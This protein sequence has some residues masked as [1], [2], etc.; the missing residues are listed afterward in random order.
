[1]AAI[2][3]SSEVAV[4]PRHL[5]G[6]VATWCVVFFVLAPGIRAQ[7]NTVLRHTGVPHDWS[8]SHIVFSRDALARHPELIHLEPRIQQQ[9]AQRQQAV[10]WGAYHGDNLLSVLPRKSRLNRD[11]N[12]NPLGGRLHIDMFPAKYSFDPNAA[13][14]CTNDYVVFGLGVPGVNGGTANFVAFNNLYSDPVNGGGLCDPPNGPGLSVLFAYNVTTVTSGRVVTSPVLSLDGTEIAFIES[15]PGSPGSAIFHVLTWTAGQGAIGAAV[16]PTQMTSLTFSPT[17]FSTTS[18]P[19][20]DYVSDTAYM[21]AGNGVLYQV[22]P[23][24][25][26]TPALSLNPNWP[27]TVS[28]PYNLTSPVLDSA[29]GLVIVGS[30]SGDLY[31]VDTTTGAIETLVIGVAGGAGSGIV[32][33]PIVDVTNGTTFIVD[34]NNGTSAV[35]VQTQTADLTGTG[36]VIAPIGEGGITGAKLHLYQPAFSNN[37]FNDPSS[38]VVSL[39]GTGLADTSPWQYV[40]G[41]TG[42][43][44]NS[45]PASSQKLSTSNSDRCTG[46]TEFFNPYAGAADT[47]TATSVASSVLTVTANNSDIAVG[48]EVYMQNT[49][50]SFLNGR[51]VIVTSLTGSGPTYTGFTAS[52]SVPDYT[53]PADTGAVSTG[54]DFFFFG[55]TQDCTLV[56]GPTGSTNGCVVAIG[57]NDGITATNTAQVT[58]GPSGI[59][60]D[61]FST[62]AQA[63]S[64]YFTGL[65]VNTAFKFTQEGLQ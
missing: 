25:N 13:P 42:A 43:T 27:V 23:V 35:L 16:A 46:W 33:P 1:M 36:T 26:G 45:L 39:C 63:S 64:I 2:L 10:K 8:Q 18:S 58:G 41:F 57:S 29:R 7:E 53:N 24:F 51:G 38:G 15:V 62:A 56:G 11:W 60:V 44:M 61:N 55:L 47:I 31:S 37:Y 54:T 59:V 49:A 3:S 20:V 17:A 19:W 6:T 40:F 9:L 22:T 52:L 50:E 14:D 4:K 65:S 32:S 30:L 34:G 21:G 48:Q 5:Y 12:V 28:S